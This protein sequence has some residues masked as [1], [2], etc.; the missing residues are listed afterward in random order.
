MKK[1]NAIFLSITFVLFGVACKS[2]HSF[3]R[4]DKI[5]DVVY[6][7]WWK[8]INGNLQSRSSILKTINCEVKIKESQIEMRPFSVGTCAIII[9][10]NDKE[11]LLTWQVIQLPDPK[12]FLGNPPHSESVID[13]EKPE[14]YFIDARLPDI[15][16]EIYFSPIGKMYSYVKPKKFEVIG[17][18]MKIYN[19]RDSLAYETM[20][21]WHGFSCDD[22]NAF[23]FYSNEHGTKVIISDVDVLYPDGT[24][25]Y[26][27]MDTLRF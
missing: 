18:T 17:F 21:Y 12:V 9:V 8:N 1:I 5:V 15:D 7:G 6:S 26:F 2:S 13:W 14:S 10:N 19:N 24:N 3:I 27:S 22:F 20:Q 23:R 25:K 11:E 4:Q 16:K